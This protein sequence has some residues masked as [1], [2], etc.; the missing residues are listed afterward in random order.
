LLGLL[1]AI[2]GVD[3]LLASLPVAA[4]LPRQNEIGVDGWALG[5]TLVLSS[6]SALIFGLAPALQMMR[7]NTIDSLKSG[8]RWASGSSRWLRGSLV[9]SEIA[10]A[11]LLLAGAG[12]MIKSFARLSEVDAGYDPKNVMMFWIDL[13]GFRYPEVAQWTTFYDQFLQRVQ[14]LPGVASAGIGTALP[15]SGGWSETSVHAKGVAPP[16]SPDDIPVCLYQPISAG[17][18]RTLG[19]RLLKGRYFT[20]QDREGSAPVAIIDRTLADRYWPNQDPLGKLIAFEVIE[21]EEPMKDGVRKGLW[22][23]VVGVVEHV[24]YYELESESRVEV[25]V[26]YPQL[27]T[28]M[29]EQRPPVG[30][31]VRTSTSDPANITSAIRRELRELDS[32]L[33]LFNVRTMED[34]LAGYLAQR[35]LTTWLIGIF[36]AIALLLALVGIYG[37]I[38][39]SVRMRRREIGIR[40]ALGAGRRHVVGLVLKEGMLLAALGVGLGLAGAFLVAPLIESLLYGVSATDPMIFLGISLLLVATA[41]IASLIPARRAASVDP[42]EALREE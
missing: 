16:G 5:F 37:V 29:R 1:L 14:R 32:D 41:L 35:R 17:F 11:L 18:H 13:P 27:P 21:T 42:M 12:L 20:E 23:E 19:I 40:I 24:R 6:L 34:V 38:A 10:V 4:Q 9:V 33:P 36:S 28:W 30:L 31:V 2:W 39:Y 26:P 25:Y 22:R 8:G 7:R 3:I 15:L